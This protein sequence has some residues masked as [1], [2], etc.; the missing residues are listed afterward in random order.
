MTDQEFE[1]FIQTQTAKL[2]KLNQQF[3]DMI[4]EDESLISID[5]NTI[6]E[7]L[8]VQVELQLRYEFFQAKAK[9]LFEY[10]EHETETYHATLMTSELRNSYRDTKSTEA[11]VFAN[12]NKNYIELKKLMLD[13]KGLYSDAQAALETINARKY[14]L[15]NLTNAVIASAE[16][17]IL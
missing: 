4:A 11:K 10:L 3:D 13:C 8:K 2:Q 14:I 16:H 17:T 1:R 5:G 12:S 6:K 9:R 7:A 15:H